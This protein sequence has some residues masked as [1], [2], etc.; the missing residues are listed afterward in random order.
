MPIQTTYPGVYVQEEPSGVRTITGVST[1]I[2]TFIGRTKMGPML[3]PT[4]CLNFTEFARTFSDDSS[5]SEMANS[6]RLFFL[7]G[8]SQCYVVRIAAGMTTNPPIPSASVTLK[9]EAT[10]PVNVL[11]VSAKSKGKIGN[12]IRLAV[13]YNG[14]QPE[15]FFN[16]EVFRWEANAAGVSIKKDSEIWASLSMNPKHSRYAIDYVNA[17]SG[18]INLEDLN[19]APAATGYS[20]S[21]PITD[22]IL[23]YAAK[24]KQFRISVDGSTY[25][26]VDLG[27]AAIATLST[28]TA[29]IK[30]AIDAVISPETVAVTPTALSITHTTIKI[31]STKGDVFI[32]PASSDDI[33]KILMLGTEQGGIEVSK[34]ADNRPVANGIVLSG[35]HIEDFSKENQNAFSIITIN[36]AI[37]LVNTLLTIT[38]PAVAPFPVM[39]QDAYTP[40]ITGNSDG[41]REKL[42]IIADAINAQK[43]KDPGFPFAA[44]VW[45]S[46]LAIIPINGVDNSQ[47]SL[48]TSGGT[49]GVNIGSGAGGKKYFIENIR[50]YSLGTTVGNFQTGGVAGVDNTPKIADYTAAYEIIDKKVD[51]FN[52]L[53][54][55]RDL[56]TGALNPNNLWGEASVFCQK[57]RAFLLMDAPE[58]WKTKNQAVDLTT[59]VNSLRIGLVKT[60]SAIFY[61]RL[62]LQDDTN[63]GATGAIAGLM[64]RTDSNRGVWKAAAG[65]EADIR[66]VSGLEY[67][68]SDAENGVLNPHAINTIRIFPNGIVNW[69]ARTMDGDD[70]FG[71]EWKY[72]PVR[73]TALFIEESLYRGLKWVVFEPND[74]PLWAQIRLNVGAFMHNLFRQGAFQGQQ[75][76]DAYFVKCDSETTTQ[77]DINLGIVNVWVGFAPLKPAEFVILH[78]Q[79]MTGQIQV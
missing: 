1:S 2:A 29:A 37:D 28:A 54:L 44:E 7:N 52:L 51:I 4:L 18:L 39:Y 64:A 34:Y 61:P 76:K 41:V 12:D 72:I 27:T 71:S 11:K 30:A 63:V 10:V 58:A 36:S 32:Q 66:G 60:H 78:L 50:Y 38:P 77:N 3:E 65:T 49:G 53:L 16:L 42:K 73:R 75:K 46:R 22:T 62:T 74:E 33:S 17:N 48:S 40:S 21:G 25:V 35:K 56:D 20:Q 9:N 13:T 5:M 19:V 68:F 47:G 43:Y 6:V 55:P 8:G 15:A 59:G 31:A 14:S 57:R 26:T 70:D 79:Q 45:G 69:G 24:S 67:R 23:N